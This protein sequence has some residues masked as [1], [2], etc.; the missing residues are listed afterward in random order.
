MLVRPGVVEDMD[1]E[2]NDI[3]YVVCFIPGIVVW[4]KQNLALMPAFFL[5]F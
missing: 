1:T 3:P 5:G 4:Q 2:N